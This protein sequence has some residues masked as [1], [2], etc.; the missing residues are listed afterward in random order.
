MKPAFLITID[1]EGDNLWSNASHATTKNAGFLP[2]FQSL[3]E[4]HGLR[5]TYLTNYEMAG[6]P[7]FQE[8]MRDALA[9]GVAEVGMHLHAWD[10]PPILPLTAD[11]M[12]Y[13][14]HLIEY[15]DQVMREKIH[16]MTDIL[17]DT[18]GVK[19]LTHRA[20]RWS[21]DHRYAH[22]LV[23]EGYQ[24]DCSVTPKVSWR[25][26]VGDP[27]RTG[28][29]DYRNF[30]D[31]A[32]WLD[33]RDISLAGDM[34]LLEVPMTILSREPAWVTHT[35]RLIDESPP[36]L[37][38]SLSPIQ[39]VLRRSF[40]PAVWLRPDGRNLSNLLQVVAQSLSENRL[41]AEF[42]L[43]SSE[44]MPGGSPA[45]KTEADIENLYA[46][47]ETLF[48]YVRDSFVGMTMAEFHDKQVQWKRT[49]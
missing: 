46:H 7:V 19:M 2:R 28:G 44:L 11:D 23:A 13:H 36:V 21:F 12:E 6:A 35:N 45:F 48:A 24:T 32:Y 49:S 17:E 5:P 33:S 3:C 39:R 31:Y 30:P 43:H 10:S 40:P 38:N 42:M 4:A 29:S 22:M 14:P 26:S 1:T 25:S 27:S 34:P 15:S 9:R 8:F 20:G 16:V 41:Y 47:L 37:R 18:F